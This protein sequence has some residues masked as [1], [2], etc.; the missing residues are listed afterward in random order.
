[1]PQWQN[2]CFETTESRIRNFIPPKI[3]CT[4]AVIAL[5]VILPPARVKYL[6]DTCQDVLTGECLQELGRRSP[7]KISH[8]TWLTMSNRI[9]RLYI[10]SLDPNLQ[11]KKLAEFVMKVYAPL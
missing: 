3:Q 6:W 2:L 7:G 1:M 10:A 11:L 8:A 9:L 4:T 5:E